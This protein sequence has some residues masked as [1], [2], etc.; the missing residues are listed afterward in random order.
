M[1]IRLVTAFTTAGLVLG[2]MAS[3][4]AGI[5]P[6]HKRDSRTYNPRV[7]LSFR[8]S[9]QPLVCEDNHEIPSEI[10]ISGPFDQLGQVDT[11]WGFQLAEVILRQH[12]SAYADRFDVIRTLVLVGDSE[13][14]QRHKVIASEAHGCD[15][16]VYPVGSSFLA[17]GKSMTF[18]SRVFAAGRVCVNIPYDGRTAVCSAE[19]TTETKIHYTVDQPQTYADCITNGRNRLLVSF[20]FQNQEGPIG[21]K[22]NNCL[23]IDTSNLPLVSGLFGGIGAGVVTKVLINQ[24]PLTLTPERP[25][26]NSSGVARPQKDS[27]TV[28]PKGVE[29]R[30]VSATQLEIGVSEGMDAMVRP[31]ACALYRN[32]QRSLMSFAERIVPTKSIAVQLGDTW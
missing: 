11:D 10:H 1:S 5:R 32:H 31:A 25:S 18:V 27:L 6:R 4:N 22:S 21:T 19:S 20:N 26:A 12:S 8:D 24:L 9:G 13:Y 28:C 17:T 15:N 30:N 23:G 2:L 16:E 14:V 3:A 7:R 29:T